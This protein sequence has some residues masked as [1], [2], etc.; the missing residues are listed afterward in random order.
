M[1]WNSSNAQDVEGC[2]ENEKTSQDVTPAHLGP[3]VQTDGWF[4]TSG[5][6]SEE[7][8]HKRHVTIREQH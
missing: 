4:F 6:T 5:T 1:V 7:H 3:W 8:G 2:G